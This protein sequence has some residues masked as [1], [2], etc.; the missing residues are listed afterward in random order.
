MTPLRRVRCTLGGLVVI[1]VVA[2]GVLGTAIASP[3]SPAAGAAVAGS[4]IV[5]L[6]A[7]GLALRI[8]LVLDRLRDRSGRAS[9]V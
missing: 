4:S 7:G 2:V 5:V 6:V 8:L 3:A 1:T 9:T